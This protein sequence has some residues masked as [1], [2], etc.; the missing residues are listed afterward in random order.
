MSNDKQLFLIKRGDWF[1]FFANSRQKSDARNHLAASVEGAIVK[2]RCGRSFDRPWRLI[3][4]SKYKKNNTR[5]YPDCQICLKSEAYDR[6]Q[7]S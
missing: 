1:T 7:K 2:G 5:L 6:R 3:I 4:Y